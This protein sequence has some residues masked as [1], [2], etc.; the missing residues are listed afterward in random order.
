MAHAAA[1]K[2]ETSFQPAFRPMAELQALTDHDLV[3]GYLMGDTRAFDAI[4][5]R[6]QGRLLNFVYRIVTHRERA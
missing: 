4:V 3:K 6:Y 5:E 2:S 1:L